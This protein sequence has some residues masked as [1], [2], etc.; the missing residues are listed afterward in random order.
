MDDTTDTQPNDRT[1]DPTTYT[2]TDD[3]ATGMPDMT[4]LRVPPLAADSSPW[5]CVGELPTDGDVPLDGGPHAPADAHTPHAGPATIYAYD[6]DAVRLH[7]HRAGAGP[8]QADSA[9]ASDRW[10]LTID[11]RDS[12]YM[13]AASTSDVL[14]TTGALVRLATHVATTIHGLH[15]LAAA[16]DDD[17]T[18]APLAVER[19]RD[20]AGG[21]A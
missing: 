21:D 18:F 6:E 2:T 11:G 14:H 15:T 20:D 7:L 4:A 8:T 1:D 3:A 9:P 5:T 12:P 13:G 19:P 10:Q 17:V 16:S